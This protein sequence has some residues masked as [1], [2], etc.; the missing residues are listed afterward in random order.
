MIKYNNNFNSEKFS[1]PNHPVRCIL[2]GP[3]KCGKYLFL[4][5]L[6]LNIIDE[7]KIYIYSPSVHQDLYQKLIKCFSDYKPIHIPKYSQ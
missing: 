5:I 6:V 3:S 4:T 1:Y 2:T 7:Y